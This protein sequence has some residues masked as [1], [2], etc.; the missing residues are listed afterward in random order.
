M[1]PERG[2]TIAPVPMSIIGILSKGK[3]DRLLLSNLIEM[4]EESTI[5]Y[6]VEIVDLSRVSDSFRTEIMK[7]AIIWKDWN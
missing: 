4:L 7:D 3:I 5:P 1:V 2:A 6:K